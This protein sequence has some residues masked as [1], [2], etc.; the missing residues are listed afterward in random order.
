MPAILERPKSKK[1]Q[2]KHKR[3]HLHNLASNIPLDVLEER[4]EEMAVQ[5]ELMSRYEQGQEVG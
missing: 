2:I 3:I 5:E 4:I 1:P